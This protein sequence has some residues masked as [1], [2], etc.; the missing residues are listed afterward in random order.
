MG[1]DVL[2]AAPIPVLILPE[3]Q[4][5]AQERERM[6]FAGVKIVHGGHGVPI[7]VPIKALLVMI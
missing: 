6:R 2:Q 3:H 7:S 4:V 1:A 5:L